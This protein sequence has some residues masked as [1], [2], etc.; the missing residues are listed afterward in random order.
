MMNGDYK[1]DNKVQ[2]FWQCSYGD[3]MSECCI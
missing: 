1:F 2:W 3:V